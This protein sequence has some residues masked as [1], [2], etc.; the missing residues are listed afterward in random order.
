VASLKL[1]QLNIERD[2]H[3]DL[4]LPFLR[5]QDPDVVCMQEVAD[6]TAKM[7]EEELN[8]HVHFV[9]MNR[10]MDESPHIQGVAIFSKFP[11]TK[12]WGEQ[13][14]GPEGELATYSDDT[15]EA[16]HQTQRFVLALAELTKDGA[17]FRVAT[18]HFPWTQGG[19]AS[20]FQREDMQKMLEILAKD[21]GVVLAGDFNAP[22]GGEIFAMLAARYKDNIPAHYT[23]SLDGSLHRAGPLPYMV[24]GIF[25]SP[26]YEVSGVTMHSGVSDHCAIIATVSKAAR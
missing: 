8:L 24:D 11:F 7:F 3:L 18:T 5:E 1:V 15:P 19:E 23:S 12:T 25:S 13:Y 2:K 17:T 21:D 20:D 6:H 14:A 4:V 26:D 16:K 9:P 22:R 10:R